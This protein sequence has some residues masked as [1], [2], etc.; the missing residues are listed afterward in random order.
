MFPADKRATH[1]IRQH[2]YS[3]SSSRIYSSFKAGR[4]A[5]RPAQ[6]HRIDAR[7]RHC[8]DDSRGRL[9]CSHRPEECRLLARGH[10]CSKGGPAQQPI[11]NLLAQRQTVLSLSLS[12]IAVAALL[13]DG[14]C[15]CARIKA[16]RPPAS[17]LLC[18]CCPQEK[19]LDVPR[20]TILFCCW[21]A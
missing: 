21:P 19:E 8:P 15:S 4:P 9:C 14:N 3:S 5:G 18:K 2:Y 7:K 17:S 10:T 16:P 20:R 11:E 12:S 6:Q 1:F 13:A